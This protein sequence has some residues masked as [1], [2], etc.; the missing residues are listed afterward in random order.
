ML[1]TLDDLN[2]SLQFIYLRKLPYCLNNYFKL[3]NVYN[4]GEGLAA[5]LNLALFHDY[6][7]TFSIGIG[8]QYY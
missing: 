1:L 4:L 6:L 8:M 5:K 2:Y 3:I 7:I